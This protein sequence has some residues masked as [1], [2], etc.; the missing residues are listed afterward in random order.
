M[1]DNQIFL[2][3]ITL[4]QLNQH[5]LN[6]VDA[7]MKELAERSENEPVQYLTRRELAN[8]LSISLPTLHDWVKKGLLKA[9]RMGNRVYFKSDEIDDSLRPINK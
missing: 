4:D 9:Y 1:I 7:R 2:Q 3:G 6:G 5:L 8:K